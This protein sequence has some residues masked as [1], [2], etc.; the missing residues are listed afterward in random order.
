MKV[1]RF[2]LGLERR[3]M[4]AG[5]IYISPWIIGLVLFMLYPLLYSLWFSFHEVQGVGQ[6]QLE[7]TGW[8]NFRKAFALDTEFVPRFISVMQDTFINTPLIMVFSLFIAILLNHKIKARALFRASFFL[9]VLIGTG[10][11]MQQLLSA[12]VGKDTLVN[13]IGVP[14]EVFLYMGPSFSAVVFDMLSRLTIV[15]WKTGVQILLFLAGLQGISP[16]LFESSRCDGAT[17]WENFWKITLP[18]ISPVILLNLVYT[19]VDSF[20]DINNR[21]MDYIK[22]T[23][24]VK[25]EMGYASAMGWIYFLFIF[26]VLILV[27][28][29]TRRLIFYTGER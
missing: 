3:K 15:F 4:V 24:F 20:T 29:L 10:L 28:L 12:G 1:K 17:E 13:G 23:A 27:F 26:I 19:L 22:D 18:L 8:D 25:I 7:P 6:L 21:M 5:Y 2:R 11:V 14:D 16:A 9:P